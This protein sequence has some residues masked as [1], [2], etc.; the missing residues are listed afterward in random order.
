M[1]KFSWIVIDIKT[2]PNMMRCERCDEAAEVPY[3]CS[4]DFVQG[5]MQLFMK[6]HKTCTER[7]S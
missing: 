3:N 1:A 6:L 7:H 2:V 4:L 5:V